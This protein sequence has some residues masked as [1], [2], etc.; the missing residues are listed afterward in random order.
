MAIAGT[1]FRMTTRAPRLS[2][3]RGWIAGITDREERLCF[4]LALW[5][6]RDPILKE[7]PL[8]ADQSRGQSRRGRKGVLLL[9]RFDANPF[10]HEG[11]VQVSAARISLRSAGR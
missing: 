10:L 5:N 9:S 11:A 4:A 6:G 1:I 8:R 2:M 7:R 3:G